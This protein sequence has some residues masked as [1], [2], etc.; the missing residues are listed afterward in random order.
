MKKPGLE[1]TPATLVLGRWMQEDQ[2]IKVIFSY[3][4]SFK[5]ITQQGMASV[6]CPSCRF[7]SCAEGTGCVSTLVYEVLGEVPELSVW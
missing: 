4:L 1:L 3:I 6:F 5:R 7:L 2:E